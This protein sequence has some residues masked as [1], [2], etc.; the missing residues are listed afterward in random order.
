METG[1]QFDWIVVW[2]PFVNLISHDSVKGLQVLNI[3][4]EQ[5]LHLVQRVW[6]KKS[7]TE[8]VVFL[9]SWYLT[10]GSDPGC[11]SDCPGN[12]G[13]FYRL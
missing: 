10:V 13:L 9:F 4:L 2:L 6:I 11:E 12:V 7:R 5:P 1:L 3:L 8:S